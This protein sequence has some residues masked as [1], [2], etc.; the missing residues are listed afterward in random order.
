MGRAHRILTGMTSSLRRGR[1][2]ET[3][4]LF[5]EGQSCGAIPA[6]DQLAEWLE[7]S[8]GKQ[9]TDQ[10][11]KAFALTP[12]F[13]C[14][15]GRELCE[16]CDGTGCHG[17][18]MVCDACLSLGTT[19]CACC[20]GSGWVGTDF[21]P[22]VFRV[23]VLTIRTKMAMERL[24]TLLQKTFS[25][26]SRRNCKAVLRECGGALLVA[27]SVL[28]ILENMVTFASQLPELPPTAQARTNKFVD[29]CC[30]TAAQAMRYVRSVLMRMAAAARHMAENAPAKS[31]ERAFASNRAERFEVLLGTDDYAG[32][33]L[34]H[35]I[36]EKAVQA[37]EARR[38]TEHVSSGEH[39]VEVGVPKGGFRSVNESTSSPIEQNK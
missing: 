39:Q 25:K 19:R 30:R 7:E 1:H 38:E 18:E 11:A 13:F 21:V 29:N 32:T 36:L 9:A 5:K 8:V 2:G 27:N 35:P 3:T 14:N 12:C 23:P 26:P 33:S 28:G 24:Q 31:I 4:R 16:Q 6:D 34:E 10:L 20:D 15:K 17:E 22:A 37:A